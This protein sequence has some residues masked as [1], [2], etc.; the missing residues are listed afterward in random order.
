MIESS[1]VREDALLIDGEWVSAKEG[2]TLAVLNPANGE[3]L[4]QVPAL[5][6]AE[7]ERAV[8]AASVAMSRVTSIE[9]RRGWLQRIGDLLLENQEELGRIITLEHGKPLKEGVGEV[10]YAAGF[11]HFFATQLNALG[12][13]TY[14]GPLKDCRWEVHHRPAGVV[15]SITPWNFPLG[16][17]AKKV[18][19]ALGC[20]CAVVAKPASA[21]PLS[22]IALA[23][24]I[25]EAG[26]P[27]GMFNLVTGSSGPISE[28]LCQHPAVR[29]VSFTGST[30]VGR[31]LGRLTAPHIKRLALELGGNAPFIV[32]PD[33]NLNAAAKDLVANKFR[34]AGQTCVCT[35][36]VYAH[37]DIEEEF[38]ETVAGLVRELRVGDGMN[39]ATDI[40]P[41][42]NRAGFDK[43]AEHVKDA[44]DGGARRVV[45]DDP[46]RPENDWGCFFPPTVITN[47]RPEMLVCRDETFGPLVAIR[48]FKD[49]AE[50]IQEANDTEYG[51]AAYLCTGD[52]Q[53][54]ERVASALRFGHVGINTGMSPT[55]ELPFGGMKQSGYGREG[56]VEGLLEFCEPQT[57]V[58][59]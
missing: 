54:A 6:P 5:S 46:V 35:N 41:L 30:E 45:G 3:L 12:K 9:T 31:Q 11:F 24:I 21:T 43:V 25:E 1:L 4:G 42:I 23:R 56:G 33:A 36:R 32:F 2:K 53:R 17:M 50:V 7:T 13:Y 10:A 22:A 15:A 55:P 40:G 58:R 20:G 38:T 26:V 48:R 14:P 34:G 59:G 19:A 28:V 29:I 8:K 27:P 52:P 51:L 57:F 47:V 49:E 37:A 18:P 44:L 39:P 16:M